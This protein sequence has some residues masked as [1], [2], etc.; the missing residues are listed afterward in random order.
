MRSLWDAAQDNHPVTRLAAQEALKQLTSGGFTVDAGGDSPLHGFQV[1]GL[2]KPTTYGTAS[3]SWGEDDVLHALRFQYDTH[4]DLY[5]QHHGRVYMGG[6]KDG[7]GRLVVEPS[8]NIGEREAA[9]Q[10]G[11]DRNQESVWDVE[12]ADTIDTEGTGEWREN[13]EPLE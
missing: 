3:N 10:A 12:G 9:V 5:E 13:H 7:E 8:E 6:W 11:H 4:R 1:G 2:R